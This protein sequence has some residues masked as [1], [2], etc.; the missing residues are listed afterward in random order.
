MDDIIM[1]TDVRPSRADALRNRALLLETAQ[2]LFE[3]QGVEAVSMS[4]VAE[5]AGVGKGTLYRHFT[6][7]MELCLSLIDKDQREL[8]ERTLSRLREHGDAADNLRWFMVET[9]RFIASHSQWIHVG[10]QNESTLAHPAHLWYRQTILILLQQL[11]V[12]GD[13]EFLADMLYVMTDV[14]T[15]D[16][17]RYA[18]G[19]SLDRIEQGVLSAVERV[20]G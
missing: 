20:I 12:A 17:Q 10:A 15:I 11:R 7:K 1:L 14:H 8:Q 19:Y 2:R 4:A 13:L 16:F 18:L 3:Q 6:N 9:V 5:A